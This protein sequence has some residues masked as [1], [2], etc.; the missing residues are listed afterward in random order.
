MLVSGGLPRYL[1][2]TG[3]LRSKMKKIRPKWWTLTQAIAWLEARGVPRS[4]SES[5]LPKAFRDG[6]I[7]TVTKARQDDGQDVFQEL[8]GADWDLA[9]VHWDRNRISYPN[10]ETSSLSGTEDTTHVYNVQVSSNDLSAWLDRRQARNE[11]S[12]AEDDNPELDHPEYRS[13][14]LKLMLAAA[15]HFRDRLRKGPNY[16]KKLE[17]E[18]WLRE[19]RGLYFGYKLSSAKI[20]QMATLIRDPEL[21]KGGNRPNV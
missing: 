3:T 4:D 18:N 7:L 16:A 2:P 13:E 9:Y 14:Y 15:A 21:G 5:E 6:K 8:D 19:N 12:L 11:E 10:G 20:T 17:I 1:T